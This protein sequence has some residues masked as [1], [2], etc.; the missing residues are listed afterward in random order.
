MNKQHSIIDLILTV[1]AMAMGIASVVLGFLNA[2]DVE[3]HITLLGIGLFTLALAG[4]Q[5]VKV[6]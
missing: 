4:L 6:E 5:K 1:V 2:A 3:T